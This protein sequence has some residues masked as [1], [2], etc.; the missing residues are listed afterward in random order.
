MSEINRMTVQ[1]FVDEG[2]LQELNRRFLHPL[3]LAL[4]VFVDNGRPVA[5]SGVWDYRDDPEGIIY[6]DGMPDPAKASRIEQLEKLR[7]A[8]RLVR[9]G[10]WVQPINED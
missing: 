8:E 10:F 1:E 7:R 6:A 9:L 2:Y 3:G 5:F 4:E